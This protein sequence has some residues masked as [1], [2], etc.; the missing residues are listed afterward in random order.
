[1]LGADVGA[2]AA[3]K[4]DDFQQEGGAV[5]VNHETGLVWDGHTHCAR[6]QPS[7]PS[8]PPPPPYRPGRGKNASAGG[9]SEDAPKFC[10]GTGTAMHMGAFDPLRKDGADCIVFLFDGWVL[11]TCADTPTCTLIERVPCE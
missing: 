9:D 7:C 2:D 1:M 5:C 6:C 3:R 8:P 10:Y 4:D 11:N